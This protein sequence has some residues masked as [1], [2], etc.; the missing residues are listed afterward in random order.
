MLRALNIMINGQIFCDRNRTRAAHPALP[1]I[2]NVPG[3]DPA[4]VVSPTDSD[5]G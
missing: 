5:K 2:K 1:R 3:N 4:S